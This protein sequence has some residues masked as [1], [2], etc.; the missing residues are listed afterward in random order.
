M[1]FFEPKRIYNG[2]FLGAYDQ[3]ATGCAGHP[4][5]QVPEDYYR[6][7]LG[8]ARIMR[9]GGDVTILT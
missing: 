6:I 4:D 3:P 2:P 1:L 9:E 8:K 7:P 5:A